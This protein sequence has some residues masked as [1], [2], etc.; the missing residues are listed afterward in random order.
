L[1]VG[2]GTG[3]GGISKIGGLVKLTGTDGDEDPDGKIGG[4]VK[5]PKDEVGDPDGKESGWKG[6]EDGDGD[7]DEK[8][9]GLTGDGDPDGKASGWE[10]S[11][12]D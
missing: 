9:G 2:T 11:S 6:A 3:V 5:L 7:L 10:Q 4:L 8:T 1:D 12:T